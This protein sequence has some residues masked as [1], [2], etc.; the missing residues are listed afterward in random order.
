M[1]QQQEQGWCARCRQSRLFTRNRYDVPHVGHILVSIVTLGLWVPVWF[2]HT[3]CNA[4]SSEPFR[5]T[6]CGASLSKS[7]RP[8]KTNNAFR[9][10]GRVV[11]RTFAPARSRPN[12]RTWTD[13][14]GRFQEEAEFVGLIDGAVTLRK[15]D[16]RAAVVPWEKLSP[17]DQKWVQEQAGLR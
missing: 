4:W 10:A 1:S 7:V 2:L 12:A 11:G 9:S 6:V 5:C 17:V 8:A 15:K 3:A 16:G 13:A 14:T